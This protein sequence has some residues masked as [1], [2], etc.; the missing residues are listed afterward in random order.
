MTEYLPPTGFSVSDPSDIRWR[1]F[2]S[3]SDSSD[4]DDMEDEED[5]EEVE[6]TELGGVTEGDMRHSSYILEDRGS[7]RRGPGGP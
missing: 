5:V 4:M 2:L 6:D 1:R 3:G 7:W